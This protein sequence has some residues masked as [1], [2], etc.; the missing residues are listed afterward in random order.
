MNHREILVHEFKKEFGDDWK[1]QLRDFEHGFSSFYDASINAMKTAIRADREKRWISVKDGLPELDE[2]VWLY[3]N[4]NIYI[5]CRSDVDN[6]GW[7]WCKT[8]DAAEFRRA[9]KKYG[10]GYGTGWDMAPEFDDDYKPSHWQPLPNQPE[11]K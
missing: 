7:L 5:G 1:E 6:E 8:Y 9:L 11:E 4:G 2:M 3:E 10:T